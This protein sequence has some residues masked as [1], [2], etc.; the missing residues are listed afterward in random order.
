MDNNNL[1][2]KKKRRRNG[3]RNPGRDAKKATRRCGNVC[4]V[5]VVSPVQK[6]VSNSL[7]LKLS[8]PLLSQECHVMRDGLKLRLLQYYRRAIDLTDG[9]PIYRN[10]ELDNLV[11]VIHA[12]D[13]VCHRYPTNRG[14]SK[15]EYSSQVSPIDPAINSFYEDHPEGLDLIIKPEAHSFTDENGNKNL[16]SG[17]FTGMSHEI[18]PYTCFCLYVGRVENAIS[19]LL[20]TRRPHTRG[21]QQYLIDAGLDY[22]LDAEPVDKDIGYLVGN[23]SRF[24]DLNVPIPPNYGKH[25]NSV[26]NGSPLKQ[27]CEISYPSHGY[28]WFRSLGTNIPPNTE[29]V[30]NYGWSESEWAN[31]PF[32]DY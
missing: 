11:R 16:S 23:S 30:C 15:V 18:P 3:S 25:I 1:Q 7:S 9:P 2:A 28:A 19:D 22:I 12:D 17:L 6:W 27:N 31:I 32:F 14:A 26:R 10:P 21:N 8:A 20:T 29:I 13:T 5:V 24:M 4:A